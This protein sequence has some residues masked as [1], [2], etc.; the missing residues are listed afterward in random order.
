MVDKKCVFLF[1]YILNIIFI[2]ME[3]IHNNLWGS[4]FWNMSHYI[5]ISYPNVPTDLNKQ[6]VK[7]YFDLLQHLLPCPICRKHYGNVL[8][9]YPLTEDILNCKLK[10]VLW[11]IT[12]HNYINKQLNKE[13]LTIEDA[14]ISMLCVNYKKKIKNHCKQKYKL[15]EI[16]I[17]FNDVT[18]D[19]IKLYNICDIIKKRE[20][21][22][23]NAK[24]VDEEL[25]NR[26]VDEKEITNFIKK[27]H[28]EFDAELVPVVLNSQPTINFEYIITEILQYMD[29]LSDEQI[30]YNIFKSLSS[31]FSITN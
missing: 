14:L 19:N 27:M 28:P 7:Q 4:T 8:L 24:I 26:K 5:T 25:K 30:K 2:F 9:L 3:G 29:E 13:E 12:I 17:I 21:T 22:L 23:A 10:L 20:K 16:N 15:E 11:L 1:L 6:T 18:D 31:I